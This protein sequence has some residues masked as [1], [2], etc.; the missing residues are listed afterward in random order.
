L[1][2]LLDILVKSGVIHAVSAVALPPTLSISL[3]NVLQGSGAN[4]FLKA[5][6]TSNITQ[7]LTSWDQD[8]TI[9]APTDEA[10]KNAGLEDALQDK[11]FVA[12]LVRLHVI[13]GRILK[14]E[15]NAEDDEA[16]MLDD[17]ARLRLRDIHHDGKTFGVRVKGASSKKEAKI[18]SSGH[19][20]PAWPTEETPDEKRAIVGMKQQRA[21]EDSYDHS[22][23]RAMTPQPGGVVYVIDRVLLP[24]D[25]DSHKSAW[26]WVGIVLVGILATIALCILSSFLAYALLREIR[27]LQ[28]YDPVAVND[29]PQGAGDA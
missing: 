27:H 6:E 1:W 20:H 2:H 24:G 22:V 17:Q 21:S 26:F 8:Y 7:I 3:F 10:F 29:T 25:S 28:G 11:D 4:D 18:T 16:S 13:P 19:A 9:F 5:F 23:V 12:R 14:L 15:E